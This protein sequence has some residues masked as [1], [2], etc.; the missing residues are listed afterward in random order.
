MFQCTEQGCSAFVVGTPPAFRGGLTKGTDI[1]LQI[2]KAFPKAHLF[3]EKPV[4]AGAVEEAFKVGQAIEQ[5]QK[6]I[7]GVA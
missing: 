6:R 2:V 7:V 5:D 1:E 3:I 4:A